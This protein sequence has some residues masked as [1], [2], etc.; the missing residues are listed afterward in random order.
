[1]VYSRYLFMLA[2]LGTITWAGCGGSPSADSM[3]R[4]ANKANIQRLTNLYTRFQ[5][6]N[7]SQGPQ[8]EAEF[9]RFIQNLDRGSLETMGVDLNDLD[10]LFISDRDQ[11]PF[12]IR[13]GVQSSFR[14]D[15]V[16]LIFE[17]QGLDGVRQVGLSTITVRDIDDEQLFSQLKSGQP[18]VDSSVSD[19]SSSPLR[20]R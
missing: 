13:Y 6:Q 8:N 11:Q 5:M 16:G 1:M 12:D 14:G 19:G 3:L 15:P 9:K 20:G 17:Q 2:M 10:S 18:Y 4:D 7:Q